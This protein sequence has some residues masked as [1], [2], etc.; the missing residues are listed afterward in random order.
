[1]ASIR[2]KYWLNDMK[3]MMELKNQEGGWISF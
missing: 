2:L 3:K 1:M